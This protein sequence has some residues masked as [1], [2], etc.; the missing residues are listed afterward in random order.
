MSRIGKQKNIIPKDVTVEV[1]DGVVKVKGPKGELLRKLDSVVKVVV[2]DGDV[3]VTVDDPSEK[4]QNSLWGTFGS[5]I[6][7]MI[8]GV[9]VGFSKDLEINGVGYRVSMQG[10][11]LKVEAGYSHP[12][13]YIVPEGITVSTEK[14]QIKIV[15]ID[16]EVVG[17]VAAEIRKIRKPE[18]Y[19]GKGIK[20]ND[21]VIRRKAGKTAKAGA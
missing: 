12:V 20:Y 1:K 14:N 6:K 5:H 13:I 3:K 15:G 4:R 10:K 8:I 16:K 21:E 19:K 2:V 11:D 7:N 18:P 17:K 9:T